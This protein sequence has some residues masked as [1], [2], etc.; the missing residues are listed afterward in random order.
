[1]GAEQVVLAAGAW[2]AQID[3]LP[4]DARVPV[5]PVKG[6]LLRLRDPAGP[7]LLRRVV[8][9]EGGYLVPRADGRYVLGATI[10]ER[11]FE[12]QP[13]AGAVYELLRDAHELVPGVSELEIEELCVGLRPGTPDNA[14]VIGPGALE[15]LIWAT[16]HHRNGILLAPLTAELLAGVL[17]GEEPAEELLLACCA[18]ALRHGARSR[19]AGRRARPER[20]RLMISLNGRSCDVPAGESLAVVLRD[21]GIPPDARGVA[22]AVDGEVVPRAAWESFALG[23]RRARGGA[24]RD[25]GRMIGR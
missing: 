17:A 16:G 20:G 4:A 19:R 13:T 18:R 6:Q 5:R 9:F 2:A 24:H 8:R 10:E 23:E 15:G 12:M 14:P 25:A 7:G 1:M 22:V 11:G 21:L 3:G